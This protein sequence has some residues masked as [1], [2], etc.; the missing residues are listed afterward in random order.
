M[1]INSLPFHAAHPSENHWLQFI[2][3]LSASWQSFRLSYALTQFI[4]AC[5][6]TADFFLLSSYTHKSQSSPYQKCSRTLLSSAQ[7]YEID[8]H[9]V[10]CCLHASVCRPYFTQLFC[11]CMWNVVA[12]C[13]C[14]LQYFLHRELSNEY[15][16]EWMLYCV[17][18][19]ERRWNFN[20]WI[21]QFQ[22]TSSPLSHTD[23]VE[24][25][26]KKN[27]IDYEFRSMH[28]RKIDRV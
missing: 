21:K 20:V 24:L 15:L 2:F 13:V 25:T 6:Y 1:A 27:Q 4:T 11:C 23:C 18:F 17:A 19:I 16:I 14:L 9:P 12:A 10:A 8:F 5:V 28:L 3:Y 22:M 7:H 26:N